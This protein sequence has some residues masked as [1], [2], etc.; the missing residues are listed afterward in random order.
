[1]AGQ[2]VKSLDWTKVDSI[3]VLAVAV[4][5]GVG[6]QLVEAGLAQHYKLYISAVNLALS[7]VILYDRHR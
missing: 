3:V 6:A 7:L 2:F 4:G 1:M 5:V